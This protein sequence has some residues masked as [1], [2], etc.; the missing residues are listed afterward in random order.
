MSKQPTCPA[1]R[2][3]SVLLTMLNLICYEL[4]LKGLAIEITTGSRDDVTET[5]SRAVMPRLSHFEAEV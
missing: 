4:L 1:F 3:T 5:D 2:K